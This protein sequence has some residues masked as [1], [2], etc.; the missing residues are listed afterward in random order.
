MLAYALDIHPGTEP[1]EQSRQLN[2]PVLYHGSDKDVYD[3]G[4]ML[5]VVATDRLATAGRALA[6]K[7]PG[8]G[9]VV[10]HLSAFWFRK[11]RKVFPNHFISA[12]HRTL[13][14]IIRKRTAQLED[15]LMLVWKA[16]P[17]P[18]RCVVR[19]YLA[20]AGW[21]DY[22]ETGQICGNIL[23]VGMTE[24]QRLPYPIICPE[25]KGFNGADSTSVNLATVQQIFGKQLANQLRDAA[26]KLYF[27]A[28]SLARERGVIIAD[29]S[30]EFGIHDDKLM[31]I[32][33]C[34][35]PD[36]TRFWQLSRFRPG[37]VMPSMDKQLLV[38]YLETIEGSSK[39]PILPQEIL[40][41]LG[42]KYQEAHRCIVGKD[43]PSRKGEVRLMNRNSD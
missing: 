42:A 12:D 33:H 1:E 35:T 26:L 13:P 31:L 38:D 43:C 22:Q 15:R 25:L 21:Q 28:W 39:L 20:G 36:N 6:Q 32:D 10:N 29:T 4:D 40:E 9:I 23:P 5:L 30:F 18:L 3:L 7:V 27:A 14:E 37:N 11:L 16:T 8:K 2:Q 17:L 19:G 41:Q 34:L 24:S